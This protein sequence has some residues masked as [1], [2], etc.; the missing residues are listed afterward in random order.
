MRPPKGSKV[1]LRDH[2]LQVQKTLK[3]P[4][5]QLL[6]HTPLAEELRYLW[7]YYAEVKPKG[8][9]LTYSELKSWSDLTGKLLAPFEVKALMQL[10]N[11]YYSG[12]NNG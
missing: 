6:E 3:R 5:K 2:L 12:L 8:S 10:D 9:P 4:P 1:P 11:L 7:H